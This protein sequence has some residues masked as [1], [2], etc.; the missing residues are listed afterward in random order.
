MQASRKINSVFKGLDTP[1]HAKHRRKAREE[2]KMDSMLS[3]YL[4]KGKPGGT[5][6][7]SG[8]GT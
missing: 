6:R 1:I 4:I 5:R 7:S 8:H 3:H 2:G